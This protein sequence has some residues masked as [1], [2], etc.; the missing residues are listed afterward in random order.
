[1]EPEELEEE[2]ESDELIEQVMKDLLTSSY[3]EVDGEEDSISIIDLMSASTVT[4]TTSCLL[5]Y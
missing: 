1:M 5:L 4:I 2:R 3:K